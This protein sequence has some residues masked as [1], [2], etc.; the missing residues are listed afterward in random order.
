[1]EMTE[2][3]R[4][5]VDRLIELILT[6]IIVL[7][8]S[9]A[10]ASRHLEEVIRVAMKDE[11]FM[12]ATANALFAT[13]LCAFLR[14]K[15][16]TDRLYDLWDRHRSHPIVEA[17]A[18]SWALHMYRTQDDLSDR[19]RRGLERLLGGA[20]TQ[21]VTTRRGSTVDQRAEARSN[22]LQQLRADRVA[23]RELPPSDVE[24]ADLLE[25]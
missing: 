22:V 20:Y 9:G 18:R 17:L 25:G 6:M 15:D 1:M 2:D 23:N 21:G 14:Y 3:Q 4:A 7:Q 12:G 13:M 11:N 24:V 8:V 16:W 5:Q 19:E 10:L